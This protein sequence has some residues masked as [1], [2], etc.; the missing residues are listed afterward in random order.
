MEQLHDATVH[1]VY[2]KL[3]HIDQGGPSKHLRRLAYFLPVPN[4]KGRLLTTLY[5]CVQQMMAW[6]Y[7]SSTQQSPLVAI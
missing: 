2:N 1:R 3:A 7:V 6:K 4:V 5:G